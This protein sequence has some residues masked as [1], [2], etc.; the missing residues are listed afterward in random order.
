M[1]QK[2]HHVGRIGLSPEEIQAA[3]DKRMRLLADAQEEEEHLGPFSDLLRTMAQI[4]Y[5][6]AADLIVLNNRRIEQQLAAAGIIVPYESGA[7]VDPISE[8]AEGE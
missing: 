4:A 1:Q 7:A 6:R 3:I 2:G 8:P 5:Q